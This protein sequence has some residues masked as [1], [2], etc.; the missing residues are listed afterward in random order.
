MK[1]LKKIIKLFQRL[2]DNEDEEE[3]LRHKPNKK[4]KRK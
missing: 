1:I 2:A 3:K 4:R